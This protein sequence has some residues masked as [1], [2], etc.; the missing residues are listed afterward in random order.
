MGLHL[1]LRAAPALRLVLWA[2]LA[3]C[4]L[5]CEEEE[6]KHQDPHNHISPSPETSSS[7]RAALAGSHTALQNC[8]RTQG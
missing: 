4:T 1:H 3:L 2:Q 6:D 5:L 8:I 7:E